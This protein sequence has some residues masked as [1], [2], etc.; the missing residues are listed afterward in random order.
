[1][2]VH[3]SAF[4]ASLVMVLAINGLFVERRPYRPI[5]DSEHLV[6]FELPCP[7]HGWA[8]NCIRARIYELSGVP[9]EPVE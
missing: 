4:L 3:G 9:L 6:W 1:M 8:P 5:H 7:Q 2:T